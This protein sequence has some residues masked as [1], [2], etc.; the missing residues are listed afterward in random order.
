[1]FGHTHLPFHRVR[2]DGVELFN[3]GSVGFPFDGD[4]RAAYALMHDDGSLEH[5]RVAYDVSAAAAALSDRFGGG[6]ARGS[7]GG[8]G[9]GCGGAA[10]ASRSMKW[11]QD[12]R[13]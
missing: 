1:V 5:R 7:G 11:L 2:D 8:S 13:R 3:P 4:D 10:W 12:A 9:G 6:S